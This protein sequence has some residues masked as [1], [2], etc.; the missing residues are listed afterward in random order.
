MKML[1]LSNDTKAVLLL[2]GHFGDQQGDTE[3]PL[4]LAEYNRVAAWLNTHK[5]RPADLLAGP[6]LDALRNAPQTDIDAA[7]L[8]RLLA[9][10]AGMAFALE[11]WMTKAVW[12]AC[13]ADDHYP[14]R[15]RQHLRSQA[16]P[17]LYGIGNRRLLEAGGL[18]VVGSRNVDEDGS[19]FAV[20][21]SRRAAACGMSIISGGARG[22][23]RIAMDAALQADGTVVGVMADNLLK[24]SLRPDIRDAIRRQQV[25]LVSPYSPEAEWNVGNA[26]GR[27]KHIY[28]LSDFA[29]VVSADFQKGGTWEGAVEELRRENHVPVFIRL[30]GNVPKGNRE[31]LSRGALA[32]PDR[33]WSEPLPQLLAAARDA[34][35]GATAV[36]EPLFARLKEQVEPT[37]S[38]PGEKVRESGEVYLVESS[39]SSSTR[40]IFEAV[41]PILLDALRRPLTVAE[42]SQKLKVQKSQLFIWIKEAIK[43]R[44]VRRLNKPTRYVAAS[45][46]EQDTLF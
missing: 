30:E 16:P 3:T 14:Q 27:N 36:Q 21:A 25:T 8:S 19:D 29:L 26:M 40:T 35:I 6:A 42:L 9:R 38:S 10:G 7:R 45:A 34:N 28:A 43:Q 37:G 2:C 39:A 17:I 15:L 44:Q 41:L 46:E 13:R 22:V 11:Q 20:E 18:A 32:F 5:Y 12:V 31:L 1:E 24:M 23:D 4:S 33:P